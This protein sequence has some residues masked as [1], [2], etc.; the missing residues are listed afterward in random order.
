M[1]PIRQRLF[2]LC[3]AIT[4]SAAAAHALAAEFERI[5]LTD[6]YFADGV[7][8]GDINRDGAIDIVSGPYWYAGP[9]FKQK[10]EIY[11]PKSL[12]PAESPSNCMFNF[13][14]DFNGDG[15]PDVLVLGRVHK[16]PAIWYENPG[17][18]TERWKSHYAFERVRGESPTTIQFDGDKTFRL[19]THWEGRWGTI[20]PDPASATEPWKFSPIGPDEAWPQF[21]HGQGVGDIN[22][23]NRDDII[24]NDGWYEQPTNANGEW[25]F[26][27]GKFSMG[28]G[29]AQMFAYDVD[30]DADAD[31]VSSL[32]AHGWG[33]AWFEQQKAADTI[34]FRKQPVMGSRD[35]EATFGVAFSQPHA[36]TIA[37]INGDGLADIITGKRRWAHGPEGDVEPS[38]APVVYWFELRRDGKEV[39]YVPH[40]V[41]D[42]SGV[43]VQ[44]QATDVNADGRADIL[45]ASK[46][47]LFLFLN[48]SAGKSR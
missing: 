24:I 11:E 16:H 45:T 8:T 19:L 23:D 14:H 7:A 1:P 12:P 18:E 20:S 36:L 6:K 25:P 44:I 4:I 10:H 15:R 5:Q 46:L 48:R 21:Y 42:N 39:R 41:D 38:A 35:E 26:H 33:L 43:G 3:L 37:D 17:N 40:L 47:G 22:G 30:G 34:R 2:S 32:D 27:A 31:V 13:V 29:G 28:K 9:T